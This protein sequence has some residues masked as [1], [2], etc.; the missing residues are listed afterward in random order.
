MKIRIPVYRPTIEQE[1]L[2]AVC[3]VLEC[4]WLGM[5]ALVEE[6]EKA[7]AAVLGARHVIAVNN[8][9]S[10]LAMTLQALGVKA[11][12]EVI[13]PSMT[14]VSTP[15][16]VLAA[17][18]KPVFCEVREQDLLIDP[19]DVARRIT[20]K[21]AA[22]IAVHYGGRIC[23]MSALRRSLGGRKIRIIED[24]AHAFGSRCE[25]G[26]AGT[27]GDAGCLS[28]D[29]IKNITCGE[30][31]AIV[32]SDEGV[33]A[34]LRRTRNLGID[35][36]TWRRLSTERPWYYEV[37]EAGMRNVMTD[38]NASIGLVQLKKLE[39]FRRRRLEVVRQ[40]D[41]EFR[42]LPGIRTLEH[43]IPG[44]FPHN[45]VIR[46]LDG[47]RDGLVQELAQRG[48][49]SGVHFI[50]CHM[51]PLFAERGVRLPVTERLYEQIVSLP[52]ASDLSEQEAAEV[53]AAVREFAG[54]G[55]G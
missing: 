17:G 10:A 41:Q 18:A 44:V 11:G 15:Q 50:P 19:E 31:G 16:A 51:Q 43:E 33:A 5:G 3:S 22:V 54:G 36:D 35:T 45:Y 34:K 21:T 40:Y 52:L 20:P 37:S 42:G 47:R 6:F 9:T 1:E 55:N 14:Y 39:R 28:F 24:A 53:I 30:G 26:Y 23:D 7:A 8:C 13:V 29:P 38:M 25:E 2:R 48:I 27:L 46:I 12:D 49:G 4:R 32:T